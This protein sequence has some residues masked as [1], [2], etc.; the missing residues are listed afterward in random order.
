MKNALLVI[1]VQDSF[2]VRPSWDT[3]SNP[4]F[5][6]NLTALVHDFR[7]RGEPVIFI[8]HID[9]DPE[10]RRG[11]PFVRVMSFLE[12][13]PDEPL[14]YKTT[15]NAFTSTNLEAH[16]DSLGVE[17]VVITGIQ[18]EQ[19]CETTARIAADLGY[20]VDFVTEATRTFPIVHGDDVFTTDEIIRRTEFVL[21]NRFARIVTVGEL[22]GAVSAT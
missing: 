10:F 16:L 20:E 3:R 9:D 6:E 1:D 14:I 18:T 11:N 5:E 15:R 17:R 4:Q 2:A 22:V 12:R 8:L 7:E 19:C 21:R 13:R